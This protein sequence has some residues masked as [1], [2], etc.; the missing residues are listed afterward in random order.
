MYVR[1]TKNGQWQAIVKV[2]GARRSVTR[3]TKREVLRAGR[4]LEEQMLGPEADGQMWGSNPT[5]AAACEAQMR[6][7]GYAPTLTAEYRRAFP[8]VVL[9]ISPS[10][11]AARTLSPR[12]FRSRLTRLRSSSIP[13]HP[14]LS[15][16]VTST[17][18]HHNGVTAGV[19]TLT[20]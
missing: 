7:G 14:A 16:S 4:M 17:E 11:A 8:H 19:V 9:L 12:S 10:A 2:R 15:R 1:E 20:H 18:L 5:V 3:P 6:T 13:P